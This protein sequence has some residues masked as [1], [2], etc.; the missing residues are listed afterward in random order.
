MDVRNEQASQ[1]EETIDYIGNYHVKPPKPT[2]V[3]FKRPR[4]RPP[5]GCEWDYENGGWVYKDTGI[6]H[7]RETIK[8]GTGLRRLVLCTYVETGEKRLVSGKQSSEGEEVNFTHS[9]LQ[10]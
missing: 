8:K 1:R 5:E 10:Q 6:P 3:M 9:N 2:Q 7:K 4:G